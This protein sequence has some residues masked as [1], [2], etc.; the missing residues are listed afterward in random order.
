MWPAPAVMDF[1][2][3]PAAAQAASIPAIS[4]QN[5]ILTGDLLFVT[6]N[7]STSEQ[8]WVIRQAGG[9]LVALTR[10]FVPPIR[11]TSGVLILPGS[12]VRLVSALAFG[13]CLFPPAR[14]VA[15]DAWLLSNSL[16]VRACMSMYSRVVTNYAYKVP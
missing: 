11:D 9:G 4:A 13:K 14:L 6:I 1:K 10:G 5:N 16:Y 7:D 15:I 12:T 8:Q 2:G 3:A